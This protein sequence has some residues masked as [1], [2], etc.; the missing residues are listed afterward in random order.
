VERQTRIDAGVAD[1]SD[2]RTFDHVS[3]G[4]AL[5]RLI[6]PY[7]TRAVGATHEFDM[8]TAFLVATTTSSF[9]CL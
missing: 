1:I 3:Y 8:A 6:F 2:G 4:E 5:D 9:L 7:T